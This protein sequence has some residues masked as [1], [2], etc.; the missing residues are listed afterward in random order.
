[1]STAPLHP[2]RTVTYCTDGGTPLAMDLYT[3]PRPP[4][5]G[6][7]VA[8]FVHG[9]GWVFGDRRDDP[10]LTALVPRLTGEGIAVASI[11]YRLAGQARFPAQIVDVDCAVRF[12]RATGAL[13]G[14]D[15]GRLA[16]IGSSAGGQLAALAGLATP[17][18]AWV[19]GQWAGQSSRPQAVV[20]LFGPADLDGGRWITAMVKAISVT[21][22]AVPGS[23]DERLLAA[24]PVAWVG[25]GEPPVLILQGTADTIV[26]PA[27]SEELAQRLRQA[28][29]P[30]TLVLVHGGQHGLTTRGER[31]S[32][33]ALI[34]TI[35]KFLQGK[36]SP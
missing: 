13:V 12:L 1:M 2:D 8:V 28:S 7:P 19:N 31:P 21:F 16:V 33:A 24:S 11:D 3:V 25:P 4:K 30:V 35:V 5:G 20:D 29:D 17:P 27:Q 14:L 15:P 22:G 26:P 18:P 23:H 6:A 36:L 10:F 34:Q 32:E 9:G